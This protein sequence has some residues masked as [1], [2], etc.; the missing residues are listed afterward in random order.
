MDGSLT[1]WGAGEDSVIFGEQ[2]VLSLLETLFGK[3]SNPTI[4]DPVYSSGSLR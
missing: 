3:T 4:L 2:S 1:L